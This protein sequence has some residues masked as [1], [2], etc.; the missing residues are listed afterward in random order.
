MVYSQVLQRNEYNKRIQPRESTLAASSIIA[1]QR[2]CTSILSRKIRYFASS[3][4]FS[5]SPVN[6]GSILLHGGVI[7]IWNSPAK[8]RGKWRYPAKEEMTHTN[9]TLQQPVSAGRFV[10]VYYGRVRESAQD[11]RSPGHRV[12]VPFGRDDDGH[13]ADVGEQL[14]KSRVLS[15][16]S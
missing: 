11:S 10:A 5:F 4:R 14:Y 3:R 16:T 7:S 15:L 2:L 13:I 9:H 6:R 1:R 12:P 8:L